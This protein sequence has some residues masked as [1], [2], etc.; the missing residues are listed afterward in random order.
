MKTVAITGANGFVGANL[1]AMFESMGYRVIRIPQ[2]ILKEKNEIL[3]IISQSDIVINLAGANILARW[4][5]K[6]KKLLYS[7]RIE[8]TK[9]IVEAIRVSKTKPEL[10]ISTSAVGIYDHTNTHDEASTHY[11]NDFLARICNDWEREAMMAEDKGVRTAIF[12]F[13][14]ILGDGGALKKMLLPFS[15]GLGG[16]IGSGRQPF[17]FMH[18][19]DLKNAY[20]HVI[21][22]KKLDGIF[23]LVAPQIITNKEFT[24]ILARLLHR[25]A[26]LSVPE[27]A[28]KIL[29]GDGAKVLT[30]GQK[31]VPKRLQASGFEFKFTTIEA[32]LQDLVGK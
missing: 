20:L 32:T 8:T 27:F 13:G 31:V 11:A 9:I 28:V 19:E 4:S 12:R 16:V 1:V 18:I 7:S 24:K 30:S 26:F 22:D 6:Y 14:I 25:P 3:K 5:K 29:F 17:P 10:F 23:N 21:N 2:S 15:F